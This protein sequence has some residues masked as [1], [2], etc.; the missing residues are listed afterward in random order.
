MWQSPQ[1]KQNQYYATN[2]GKNIPRRFAL[3]SLIRD[4][5]VSSYS[6]GPI[7]PKVFTV[8]SYCKKACNGV[9]SNA[10]KKKQTIRFETVDLLNQQ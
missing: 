6:S 2:D 4:Y 7:D 9:R 8:P 10:V 1:Y 3:G 5:L